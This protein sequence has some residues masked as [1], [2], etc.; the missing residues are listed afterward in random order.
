[1]HGAL[2]RKQNLVTAT[3]SELIMRQGAEEHNRQDGQM[4]GEGNTLVC[5]SIAWLAQLV[6]CQCLGG[7]LFGAETVFSQC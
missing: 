1:M 2:H 7:Q 5:V 4:E 3:Q 6:S